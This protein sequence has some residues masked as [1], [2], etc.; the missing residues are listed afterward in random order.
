MKVYLLK[1]LN[2]K[3]KKGDIIEVSDGYANNYLIPKKIAQLV[4][5]TVLSEKK[6]KDEAAIYRAEE[7]K[8]VANEVFKKLDGK[9]IEVTVQLGSNDKLIGTVTS[10]EVAEVI[11]NEFGI[12]IDKKKIDLPEIKTIGIFEFKVKVYTGLVAKMKID[13]RSC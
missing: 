4:D 3:G 6:S 5:S 13:V 2:G 8:K 12:V 1:D 7:E 11:R 10:K 9:Q